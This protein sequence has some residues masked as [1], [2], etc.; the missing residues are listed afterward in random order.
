MLAYKWLVELYGVLCTDSKKIAD[1]KLYQKNLE[2]TLKK[3][4][5]L[6]KKYNIKDDHLE[7]LLYKKIC[8]VNI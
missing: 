5:A 2:E 4:I 7:F 3:A 6:Q 8:K 1:I